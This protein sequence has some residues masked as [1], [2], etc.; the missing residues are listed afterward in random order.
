METVNN[1]QIGHREWLFIYP[2]L[3]VFLFILY[4]TP[5]ACLELVNNVT[6]D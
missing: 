5:F 4:R 2:N 1:T 6:R 3:L